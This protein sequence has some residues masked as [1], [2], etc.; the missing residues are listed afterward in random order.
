MSKVRQCRQCGK[1]F[2]SLGSDTCPAC[3]E[4]M[5]EYFRKVKNYLYDHPEANVTD[6]S[7]GAQVP[8]KLVLRFL[9]EGRLSVD[10]SVCALECERCGAPISAGRYCKKCQ[11]A[12]QSAFKR[13]IP[14]QPARQAEKEVPSRA[15]RAKMHFDYRSK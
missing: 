2:T 15:G 7:E 10:E 12:L 11:G 6:I 9:K 5:D 14:E 8:E 4:E 3:A 13:V 1:L